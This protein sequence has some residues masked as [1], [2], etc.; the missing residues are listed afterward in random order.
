MLDVLRRVVRRRGR[1][2]EDG[3]GGVAPATLGPAVLGELEAGAVTA[4]ALLL[5]APL[6]GIVAL[7]VGVGAGR[8]EHGAPLRE[9]HQHQRQRARHGH[10]AHV[11]DPFPRRVARRG[12]EEQLREPGADV[13]AGAREPRDDAQRSPGDEGDDAERGAAGGLRAQGEEHHGRHGGREPARAAEPEAEGA[14]GGLEDPDVPEARAHSPVPRADVGEHAAERARHE[15][16]HAEA[17]GD[18][19]GDADVEVELVVE[20][21][22]DDVVGGELHAHAVAVDEDE[23]PGAVVGDGV[24]EHPGEVVPPAAVAALLLQR[25]EVAVGEVLPRG[26]HE[27]ADGDVHEPRHEVGDPPRRE[28]RGAAPE[29]ALVDERHD[30]LRG[31]AAHVA[32][33]GRQRVD[34]ADDLD[35]EH[36]AGPVLARDEGGEG[37]ADEEPAHDVARGAVDDGHAE[38]RRRR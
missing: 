15:V 24:P 6:C 22:G 26:E 23:D 31:A 20:E 32:P 10:D 3:D 28:R 17:G 25:P 4:Y 16:G 13:A 19:A 33:P 5:L 38:H 12:E 11:L 35:V 14:A 37:E 36:G 2:G 30:E 27:D 18:D 1:G 29:D 8:E 34:G 9:V 7:L 21:L